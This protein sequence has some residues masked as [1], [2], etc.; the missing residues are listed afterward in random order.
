MLN[1]LLAPHGY[2]FWLVFN[3]ARRLTYPLWRPSSGGT[4]Q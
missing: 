1:T 4:P 3:L 2:P